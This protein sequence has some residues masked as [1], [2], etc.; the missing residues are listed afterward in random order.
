MGKNTLKVDTSQLLDYATYLINTETELNKC[1]DNLDAMMS[2]I[3]NGWKD[4]DG[5]EF[6]TSFSKFI[7]EAKKISDETGKLGK[8][9][10]GESANYE[11]AINTALRTFGGG[12]N[13]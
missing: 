5:K 2:T 7:V 11:S 10:K 6:K 13:G 4:D 12:G 1:L 8:F 3:T 9:A